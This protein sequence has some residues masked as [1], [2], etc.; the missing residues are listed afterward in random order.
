MT[1]AAGIF[2]AFVFGAALLSSCSA[3]NAEPADGGGIPAVDAAPRT[4]ARPP[5]SRTIALV[6]YPGFTTQDLI[7]PHTVFALTGGYDVQLAWKTLDPVTSDTGVTIT[8]TIR[9]D[10]VP[11]ELEVLFVPGTL[12]GL[13]ELE[14]E[15]LIEFLRSRGERARFVTSVCTG[16]L[17]LGAAG[18]LRGYR[19]TSHWAARDLLP[20]VGAEP[21]EARWVQD[22]N[23][24][25]GAGVTAGLDFG[26]VLASR[27]KDD[28]AAQGIQ[29]LLEYDPAPPFDAGSPASA[30]PAVVDSVNALLAPFLGPTR[31]ALEAASNP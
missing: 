14:D 18:L 5:G 3:G 7:G 13:G 17:F 23:R 26:L 8:P 12:L 2:C 11:R 28:A 24:V 19:A 27:L 4:D 1:H 20:L 25:T 31:K 30:P 21:I 22:R 6:L 16:S 29:L 10:D 15:E 9:F